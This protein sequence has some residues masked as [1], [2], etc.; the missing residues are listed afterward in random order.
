MM[1]NR[2]L[3]TPSRIARTRETTVV[4]TL[5]PARLGSEWAGRWAESAGRIGG[6][7]T[8]R[9]GGT[10]NHAG[11]VSS[12]D[13]DRL[14]ETPKSLHIDQRSD[15]VVVIDDSDRAQT[16]YPDGEKHDD[17]DASGKKVSTKS[18]WQGDI[19]VA[20]TNLSHSTKLTQTFRV[21][22]GGKQLYV[23]SRLEAPSLQGP[24]SIRRVFD[25]TNATAQSKPVSH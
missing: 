2:R 12:E 11:S 3:A 19:L 24:V 5:E 10:G 9:R 6:G 8:G 15:Q 7:G 23:V 22:E 16:F 20:E 14:A 1:P 21:S 13:W 18:E 4:G 17:Q 25:L